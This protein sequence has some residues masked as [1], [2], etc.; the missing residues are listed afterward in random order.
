MNIEEIILDIESRISAHKAEIQ[1]LYTD[2][3]VLKKY[4]SN[5]LASKVSIE[6]SITVGEKITFKDAIK[7]FLA[8]GVPKRSRELYEMFKTLKNNPEYPHK[9][10][11]AQLSMFKGVDKHEF[12]NRTN[13]DKYYY[14]LVDWFDGDKLKPEYLEKI[15]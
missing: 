14:G 4:S 6:D 13:E 15:E 2:L 9:S 11:S 5:E 12:E 10:F 3:E 8:D 7:R 1:K